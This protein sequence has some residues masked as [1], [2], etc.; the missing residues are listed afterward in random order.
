MG[1]VYDAEQT[2]PVRRRVALKI[3][4]LGMDTREVVARFEAERQALA[5]MDHP[6]IARVLDAGATETGR[7]YFVM[8][9]VRGI[10]INEYCYMNK[11]ATR[12]RLALFI[13]V[14]QAVQH[15]HQKGVIHRD[16]KP[17]NVLVAVQDNVPSPKIIDFGIAKAIGQ[18]LTDKTLATAY[19]QAM[20]T[21]AY[22]SPEQAEMSGLD[23][24]TR[25][26]I[27]SLGVML[28]E[29]LVGRLPL[30]PAEIGVPAFIA[31]LVMRETDPQTPSA[32]VSSLGKE[33]SSAARTYHTDPAV[34]SREFRGDLD[35]I[36]MKAMEKD[37]TR[38]YE[39]A[40]GLGMDL[41]RHLNDE[42]VT[43]RAPSAAYRLGKF[44][45]RNKA[46]VSAAFVVAAGLAVGAALATVGMVR[47]VR[48]ERVAASEA[49]AA[50]QVAD[51]LVGLFEV[52]DPDEAR[53]NA[54]TAR[55]ILDRGVQH[56]SLEL[57]DQPITQARL[58][59][60]MARVYGNLGLLN[61]A[62]PLWEDAVRTRRDALGENHPDFASSLHGLAYLYVR[63]G[64]MA[65]AESL[66]ARALE[67][68]D[69]ALGAEH[70]ATARTLNDLATLYRRQ[71]KY[72]AAEPLYQQA[73]ELKQAALGPDHPNVA[74]SLNN[75]AILYRRLG[76]PEEAEPL[77]L[78]ALEIRE[79]A[80]GMDHP[81]TSRTVNSLAILY[82]QQ[83]NDTEA[84]RFFT[85]ALADKERVLGPDHPDV[86]NS[87]NNL[88]IMY[89]QQKRY[90]EA[91][92]MFQ[93]A[94][95][96]RERAL[97]LE[98]PAVAQNLNNLAN[99]YDDTGRPTEAESLYV[100][101]IAIREKVLG[102]KHPELAETL[103]NLADLYVDQ[104]R[105]AEAEAL[106]TRALAIQE[107]VLPA[108]HSSTARTV[109][110]YVRLLR[111]TGREA[112]A[113]SL[114]QRAEPATERDNSGN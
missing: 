84:E 80:L 32:R 83:G 42:P 43:A 61:A 6:N 77:Y 82:A 109:R 28:Y 106:L 108:D 66:Y 27:Y 5:V 92:D 26:D 14:C 10:P 55:E 112:E 69:A 101:A 79:N 63:L 73:L 8:E 52:S 53:G 41:Q 98:H 65:A 78:R 4:K 15:A 17:S 95:V 9:H 110:D 111:A 75:L 59:H 19:G 71:G 85:R 102:P 67:I 49:E 44:V 113:D 11:L 56:I 96:I 40:N 51:F 33:R 3:M 21:P 23:V 87:V 46:A 97:G 37:R 36:V 58:M 88:A 31:K 1:I 48:A 90:G 64:E 30:D 104:E 13:A 68:R 45:K 70:P 24:D 93:R 54:V 25:T 86:A 103:R 50:Q 34:L 12:E 62:R 74:T 76:R 39:T 89:A 38:R 20:G 105:F 2:E 35:W 94:L 114:A 47:A 57:E 99:L 100:R 16:L 81:A 72:D 18:R 7:P 107:E 60:T 22:M 29:L 91:E